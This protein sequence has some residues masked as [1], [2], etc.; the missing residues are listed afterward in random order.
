MVVTLA[1]VRAEAAKFGVKVDD[2]KIGHGHGC[3]CYAP[4]GKV[5]ASS[6]THVLCEEVNRPWKPDY[7]DI[8]VRLS[9]GLED[10]PDGADCDICNEEEE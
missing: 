1:R 7:A 2:W 9:D 4:K 6:H 3:D 10:C 5:F 8:L